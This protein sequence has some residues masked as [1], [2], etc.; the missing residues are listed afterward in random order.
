MSVKNRTAFWMN[1]RGGGLDEN[2][3]TGNKE[4]LNQVIIDK[5]LNKDSPL[6][7][8]PWKRGEFDQNGM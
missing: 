8:G 2:L 1:R 6:K 3:T 7:N 5:Y 4:F